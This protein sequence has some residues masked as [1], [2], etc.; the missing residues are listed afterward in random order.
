MSQKY[1]VFDRDG[2]LIDLIPYISDIK[3]VKIKDDAME[4]LKNLATLGYKFGIVTNQSAISRGLATESQVQAINC[5][6]QDELKK[7]N[8]KFD[9]IFYC[10]HLPDDDCRCRKPKTY[11]LERAINEFGLNPMTSYMVGDQLSDLEF[12]EKLGLKSIHLNENSVY[13]GVS[14]MSAKTLSEVALLISG[15]N[16][17]Q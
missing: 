13:S 4:S 10:P 5:Y 6:I 3:D 15:E 16:F 14:R 8:I 11:F 7:A 1:I 17:E 12:G 9:F 2:T